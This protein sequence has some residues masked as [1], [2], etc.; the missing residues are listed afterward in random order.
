VVNLISRRAGAACLVTADLAVAWGLGRGLELT[1]RL[2]NLTDETHAEVL[3][4]PTLGGRYLAGYAGGPP[5]GTRPATPEGGFDR[6]L[7]RT[8][9]R[10]YILDA[11]MRP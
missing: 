1:G 7:T 2:L 9:V 11:R 4:H 8:V 3:G 5:P 10:S 6:S